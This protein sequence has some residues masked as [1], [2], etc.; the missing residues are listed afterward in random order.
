MSTS[1]SRWLSRRGELADR[2]NSLPKY[3]VS[4]TLDAARW[5]NATV[6]AGDAAAEV[7][8]LREQLAGDIVVLASCQLVRTLLAHDL[9]DEFR[10]KVFPVVLGTGARLFGET[11]DKRLVRLVQSSTL[12]DGLGYLRYERV[13]TA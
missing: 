6:L 12:G 9:V 11:S 1:A 10:L 5:S 2:L 7:A 4:A 13:R 3:V 8:K